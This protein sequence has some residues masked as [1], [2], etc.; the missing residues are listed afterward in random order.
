MEEAELTVNIPQRQKKMAASFTLTDDFKSQ[1]F[2]SAWECQSK[3]SMW[4]QQD[5]NDEAEE[6][7]ALP[8]AEVCL[9]MKIITATVTGFTTFIKNP[10]N[11][12]TTQSF[13]LTN[14]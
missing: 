7:S 13:N 11:F 6:E 12:E 10:E 1:S 2:S 8:E 14:I 9:L 5:W 4:T 3:G